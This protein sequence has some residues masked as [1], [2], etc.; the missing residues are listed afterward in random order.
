MAEFDV[1]RMNFSSLWMLTHAF[2][3]IKAGWGFQL[4]ADVTGKICN[5]SIDLVAFSVTS[6][7]KR[8]NTMCLC[9]IPSTTESE[10]MYTVVYHELR[11]AVCLVPS[12]KHCGDED[13][14]SCGVIQRLLQDPEVSAFVKSSQCEDCILPVETAMCDN[15]KGW[16]NFS[17]NVLGIKANICHTH[18]TGKVQAF[19]TF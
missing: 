10:Q 4:N 15:F 18:A 17:E 9:I 16:G 8:N 12:I 6:I 7:P 14:V 11:K 1:L 19:R 13:C 5:K 2:R 3:A